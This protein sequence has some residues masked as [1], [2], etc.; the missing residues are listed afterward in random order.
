VHFSIGWGGGGQIKPKISMDNF[1]GKK[2]EGKK[3]VYSRKYTPLVCTEN[4]LY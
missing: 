1:S 2:G 3:K 4:F